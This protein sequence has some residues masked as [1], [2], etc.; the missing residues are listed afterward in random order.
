MIFTSFTLYFA[1]TFIVD[2]LFI[3]FSVASTP[4]KT[5]KFSLGFIPSNIFLQESLLYYDL[6]SAFH[7]RFINLMI[8][9]YFFSSSVHISLAFSHCRGI[10]IM[11]LADAS[12]ERHSLS[13]PQIIFNVTGFCFTAAAAIFFTMY[14]K[15]WLKDLRKE[16]EG[17][18]R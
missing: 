2:F 18:L 14:A 7:L 15:K 17:L 8:L 6:I 5:K 16:E 1:L 12:K 10:L 9:F 4:N 3:L 11:T 13:A